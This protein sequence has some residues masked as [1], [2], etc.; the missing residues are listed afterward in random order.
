MVNLLFSAQG[1][2]NRGR[3]WFGVLLQLVGLGVAVALFTLLRMLMP[4]TSV[5]GGFKADGIEAV[6]YLLI[7]L[8]FC[9][10]MVWSG[11]CLGVKRY[12]DRSKSGAW[13]LVQ[14]IPLIGSI[15]Y[16][17]EAGCLAGTPGP[18]RF[19]LVSLAAPMSGGLAA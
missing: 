19:G 10:T 6:P 15:W 2:I 11:I 7:M 13:I 9:V 18:N 12:H 4:S 3:F 17:V 14:F 1:R 16:L 8:G 5:D